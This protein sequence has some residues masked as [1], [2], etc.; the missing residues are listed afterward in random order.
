MFHKVNNLQLIRDGYEYEVHI[1]NDQNYEYK[2]IVNYKDF[3]QH[4]AMWFSNELDVAIDKAI[5]ELHKE[6]PFE[7]IVYKYS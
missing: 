1:M 4:L 3:N 7:E 2:V 6:Y 5:Q